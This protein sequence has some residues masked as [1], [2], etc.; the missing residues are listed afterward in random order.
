[1]SKKARKMLALVLVVALA[2]T[3]AV[4]CGGG[5]S[6]P[7][8]EKAE[9]KAPQMVQI[10]GATSGGTYFLLANAIAQ[11][12]NTK[13]PDDFKASAQSTA[14]TPIN[15]RLLENKEADFAFGQA[16]I[17][18]EALDGVGSFDKK[19]TNISSV[20]Y[21][22]PN[23]MQVPAAADA[24]ITKF[25]DFKGKH[26][27][28]GASGSAT[29]LNSRDMAKMAGLDYLEKKDFTPEFTSEAQSAELLKNRQAEGACMIGA[30]GSAAM[31]DIMSTGKFQLLQFSDEEIAALNK[32]NPAY[33]KFIIPA[34]T[35]PNQPNDVQTFAVAN[36]V[37]ARKDLPEE[38]VYTF[39]K[40]IYE[41]R[42]ELVNAHKVAQNIDPKNAVSGLTVPLHPGAEKYYKEIGAVK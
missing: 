19:H 35:Y 9:K 25:A 6:Q 30:L 38:L 8:A 13:Y 29:E 24:K 28:V 11:M 27:A 22:Y 17:A 26:F 3:L 34:N 16:G 18:K 41:N 10:C 32:M 31:M 39:T 20:T 12:V 42:A 1:M 7:A 37:F 14:G 36:Y 23:V 21:V 5:A 15:L 2:A 40:A 33:F 4:G